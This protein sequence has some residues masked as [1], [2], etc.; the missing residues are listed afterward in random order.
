MYDREYFFATGLWTATGTKAYGYSSY[1]INSFTQKA[2]D[3]NLEDATDEEIA[4]VIVVL[5]G[6]VAFPEKCKNINR[7]R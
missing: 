7:Q 3:G 1:L 5:E 4:H 2:F 6:Y